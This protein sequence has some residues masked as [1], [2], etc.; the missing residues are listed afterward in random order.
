[1]TPP[2]FTGDDVGDYYAD[3]KGDLWRLIGYSDAPT[4]SLE[5]VTGDDQQVR[6]VSRRDRVGGAVGAPIF[7]GFRKMVPE[8]PV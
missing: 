8:E 1:M 7:E 6:D 4:A 2:R 5:R 3:A